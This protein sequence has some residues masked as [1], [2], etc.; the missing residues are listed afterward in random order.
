MKNLNE[1]IGKVADMLIKSNYPVVLTGTGI[2]TENNTFEA[3]NQESNLMTMLDPEEFTIRRYREDPKSFFDRGTPF[4]SI[5]YHYKPNEI[6]LALAELEKNNLIK[7][8]ITQ[9][10]DGLHKEAG[11]KKVFEIHGS[12]KTATCT[13]CEHKFAIEDLLSDDRECELP[14]KCPDC[15]ET[16]KPDVAF[17]DEPLPAD[18]FKAKEETK[19]ADLMIIIGSKMQTSPDNEIPVPCKNIVIINREP[20]SF[21]QKASVVIHENPVLVIKLLMKELGK[22][23]LRLK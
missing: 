19:Q 22:R 3:V 15:G 13:H 17:Y 14:P 6:H 9:N 23:E 18:F 7:S 10:I 21:D 8:I 2:L 16:L 4:F 1:Q 11:S 12:I 20:T 5:I